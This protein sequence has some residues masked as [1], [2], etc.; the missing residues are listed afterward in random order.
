MHVSPK[1]LE[2]RE[3]FAASPVFGCRDII[4]LGKGC[5]LKQVRIDN[6]RFGIVPR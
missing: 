1:L 6:L 3:D 5:K 2:G 4:L